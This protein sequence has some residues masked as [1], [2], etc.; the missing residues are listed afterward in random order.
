MST[1]QAPEYEFRLKPVRP[2]ANLVRAVVTSVKSTLSLLVPDPFTTEEVGSV[3]MEVLDNLCRYAHEDHI[4]H[5]YLS[6]S[7]EGRCESPLIYIRS[8]NVV[9]DQAMA[10]KTL[11][12]LSDQLSDRDNAWVNL[13]RYIM[14]TGS[15][16]AVASNGGMGL[17][18]IAASKRSHVAVSL[19]G[20]Q[21]HVEVRIKA[22]AAFTEKTLS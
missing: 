11:A 12:R 19:E 4:D 15:E 20:R 21:F 6:V 18:E 17:L 16:A 22:P 13:G 1:D 5:S 3:L 14:R 7:Y 9:R 8:G 10:E 2:S